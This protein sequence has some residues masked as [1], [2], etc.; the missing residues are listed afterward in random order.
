[1]RLPLSLL[2]RQYVA[3]ECAAREAERVSVDDLR[4]AV[5][6]R[7]AASFL[8]DQAPYGALFYLDTIKRVLEIDTATTDVTLVLLRASETIV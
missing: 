5:V 3:L 2:C 8:Y 7:N 6:L 1:M 4:Y